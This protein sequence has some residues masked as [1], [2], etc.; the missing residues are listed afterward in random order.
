MNGAPNLRSRQRTTPA[1]A[2]VVVLR[3]PPPPLP[4]Y[5]PCFKSLKVVPLKEAAQAQG[6]M[7]SC[8]IFD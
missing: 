2:P 1:A 7:T 3:P 6:W 5:P 4:R 8:V